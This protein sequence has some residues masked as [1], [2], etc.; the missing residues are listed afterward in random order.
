MEYDLAAICVQSYRIKKKISY[1]S[2]FVK[3]PEGF[4]DLRTALSSKSF[5]RIKLPEDTNMNYFQSFTEKYGFL[6][7]LS[8]IDALFHLGPDTL[9]Y[10]RNYGVRELKLLSKPNLSG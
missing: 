9:Q 1:T 7:D 10:I 6:P 8:I 3:I 5:D 4:I 2:T